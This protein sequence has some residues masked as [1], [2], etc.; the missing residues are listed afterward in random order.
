M[1]FLDLN[2]KAKNIINVDE[3]WLNMTDFRRKHWKLSG[4]NCSVKSKKL[5]PRIS[6]ITGVD[7]LGNIY[8]SLTQSN[9]NKSMMGL[10]MEHLVVKLDRQN[11]HW[12]QS[13]VI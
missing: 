3:T 6:M 10:F 11:P 9:S 12:R 5:A 1:A 13:T 2:H 7:K 4:L 8:L